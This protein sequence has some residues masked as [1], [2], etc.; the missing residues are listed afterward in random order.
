[1]NKFFPGKN[2]FSAIVAFLLIAIIIYLNFTNAPLNALSWDVFGYYLYLPMTFIYSD[3]GMK[4]ISVI[5]DIIDKYNSTV[6]LYQASQLPSGNWVIYYTMGL[7]VLYAPFFLI[8]HV[9]SLLSNLPSD[10]FSLPY[11]YSVW[12]GGIM[13]TAIGILFLRKIL[14]TFFNDKICAAILII[15]VLGTNYL[16]NTSFYGQNLNNQNFIFTLYSII[17]WLTILWHQSHKIKHAVLLALSCGLT[18]LI[19]PSEIVCL[20]IPVLWGVKNRETAEEKINLLKK[21]RYQLLLFIVLLIIIGFFQFSYWKI[22]TGKFLYNT[23]NVNPGEGFEFLKP[24]TLKVLFSFRKGWLIYTPVM[25]FSLVG[26]IYLRKKNR[27]I[28]YPVLIYFLFN[29]YVVSSWSA[30]WYADCFGQRALI[31]SYTILALPLG[32]FLVYMKY[33]KLYLKVL[34]YSLICMF[35]GLNLFQAWQMSNGIIHSS[36]MTRDYYFAVFGKTYV[37]D[38][39]ERLLLVN[40]SQEGT[41][42]FSDEDNYRKEFS[43]IQDFEDSNAVGITS[44]YSWSGNSSFQSDSNRIFSPPIQAE[45]SDIIKSDHAWIKTTAHVLPVAD[46]KLYPFSIVI[47]FQHKGH[48]YK[49]RTLNSED[50]NLELNRWNEISFYYLTPEVRRKKDKLKVYLWNRGQGMVYLDNLTVEIYEQKEK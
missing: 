37:P 48:P 35:T 45:F 39:A 15:I 50:L 17:I 42:R 7:A 41:D 36:R 11:Q 29:L 16:F 13:Y 2:S 32:Y 19:R 49:Y 33:R 24:Y 12:I 43:I 27:N 10:G 18:I 26:F 46:P 28:F 25:I 8:G 5:Y 44:E 34:T 22:I 6:T 9:I 20:I 1:M 23:Y 40:R 14:L 21:Y 47:H 4:D 30:W 38:G 31:P 3:P